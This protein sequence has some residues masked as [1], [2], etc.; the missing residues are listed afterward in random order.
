[1]SAVNFHRSPP[2]SLCM[3]SH[4]FTSHTMDSVCFMEPKVLREE[5][6]G[7]RGNLFLLLYYSLFLFFVVVRYLGILFLSGQRVVQNEKEEGGREY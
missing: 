6:E 4:V 3:S 5:E 7:R 1:M 2:P